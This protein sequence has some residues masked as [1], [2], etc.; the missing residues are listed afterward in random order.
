MSHDHDDAALERLLLERARGGD[1]SAFD[2][3]VVRH[4]LAIYG[5]ARR[6]LGTHEEADE[7]A[8][9]TFVRAWRAL[10]GFRGESRI[11]TW[12]VRI[13]LNVA[14]TI[15]AARPSGT[16]PLETVDQATQPSD[17][18]DAR[19]V[20]T[21]A[22]ARVRRAVATLPPRQREVVAL[23]VFSEM[24]YEDVAD[25]MGLTVGA[26]KAHLHQAVANL[27]RRMGEERAS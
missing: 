1:R 20:R 13:A 27:R 23:K 21:Q 3:I 10:G 26:V 17:A 19:L 14:R 12:L 24:T 8:Q 18:A 7:A 11:R 5:T 4:R 6:I 16:V 15:V 25:A 22:A 9:E 2:E